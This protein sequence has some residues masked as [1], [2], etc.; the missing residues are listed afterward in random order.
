MQAQQEHSTLLLLG[1]VL[2][3]SS[4]QSGVWDSQKFLKRLKIPVVV[5]IH[6]S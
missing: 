1:Y 4:F 2:G 6:H 5:I 3:T